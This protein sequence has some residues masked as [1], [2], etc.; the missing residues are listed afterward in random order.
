MSSP[1]AKC[2]RGIV[3]L[4]ASGA[5][6]IGA[7]VDCPIAAY[8]WDSQIGDKQEL[9]YQKADGTWV[10]IS[11]PSTTPGIKEGA[12]WF[13][14]SPNQGGRLLAVN[15]INAMGIKEWTVRN[16]QQ[17]ASDNLYAFFKPLMAASQGGSAPT[18]E[19]TFVP[20]VNAALGD[21]FIFL[22]TNNDGI[23]EFHGK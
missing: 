8:V 10:D 16:F 13:D 1:P 4:P 3:K 17:W 15:E 22:D 5:A 6:T 9:Q 11:K 19:Q 23:P 14:G 20:D 21:M 18:T 7:N 12:V 2:L